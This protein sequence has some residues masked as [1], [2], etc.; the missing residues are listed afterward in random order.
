MLVI[1]ASI[2]MAWA[3][4]DEATAEVERVFDHVT[5][6]S[7]VAPLIWTLEVGNVLIVAERRNRIS[8]MEAA[9]FVGGLQQL[10]IEIDGL[11]LLDGLTTIM[12]LARAH[13]LSV[14]DACYLE[15]ARR[16]SLPLATLDNRLRQAATAAHV[17]LFA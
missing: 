2:T 6:E 5:L 12:D 8:R 7:A 9:Q 1:D 10:R 15:L 13:Q 11:D 14:Y 4:Q 16:R 17:P 3:F